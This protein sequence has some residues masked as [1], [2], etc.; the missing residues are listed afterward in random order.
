[1]PKKE[2]KEYIA[3]V[4]EIEEVKRISSLAELQPFVDVE[5]FDEVGELDDGTSCIVDNYGN[6]VIVVLEVKKN[7]IVPVNL[8]LETRH[9]LIRED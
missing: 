1:M 4:G 7:K 6:K 3:V 5:E 2:K 9:H 8:G